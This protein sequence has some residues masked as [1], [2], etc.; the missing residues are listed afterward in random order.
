MSPAD[1]WTSSNSRH[2]SY[3]MAAVIM[4]WP[5]GGVFRRAGSP[6]VNDGRLEIHLG[7]GVGQRLGDVT[8]ASDEQ[9]RR[10]QKLHRI[11]RNVGLLIRDANFQCRGSPLRQFAYRSLDGLCILRGAHDLHSDVHISAA[12]QAVI[13]AIIMIQAIR[14]KSSRPVAHPAEGLGADLGLDASAAERAESLAIFENE[15]GRPL[16]LRR[17]PA[18][19]DDD[20]QSNG[21]ASADAI[22][23]SVQEF[24]HDST[25]STSS[26]D[27]RLYIGV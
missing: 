27:E 8:R 11:H 23:D 25:D 17:T 6:V 15:H 2:T 12:E 13:P 18:S 7:R 1:C 24:E 26:L 14:E 4:S 19:A 3:S 20:A 16:I 21:L 22:E 10:R 5:P 9:M